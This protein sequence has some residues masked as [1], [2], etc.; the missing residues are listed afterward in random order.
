MLW[1]D[2]VL[3]GW[4]AVTVMLLPL[5]GRLLGAGERCARQLEVGKGARPLSP[6]LQLV[7]DRVRGAEST[8]RPPA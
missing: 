7:T 6:R 1:V 4:L 5:L 8:A 3:G 2:R